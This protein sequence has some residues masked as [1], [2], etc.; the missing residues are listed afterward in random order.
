M[1]KV[2]NAAKS[3][4]IHEFVSGLPQAYDSLIGEKG[5]K[6]SGGQRQR[7]AIARALQRDSPILILDEALSAVDAE[8]EAFIQQALD[9]LMKGRTTLAPGPP[10]FQCHQ[11]RPNTLSWIRARLLNPATTVN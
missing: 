2:T 10:T 3:A 9:R 8:N 7:V 5:I 11:L 4:N 1:P 6:L